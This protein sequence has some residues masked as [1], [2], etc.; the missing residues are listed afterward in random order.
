[1]TA[2]K[3][4][5][6]SLPG[7]VVAAIVATAA[8]AS[9]QDVSLNYERLSSMEEPLATEIGALTLVLNGVLDGALFRDVED[10]G[11]SGAGLTSNV[12]I[13]A[14]AQL[15][16]RWRVGAIWFGQYAASDLFGD[17]TGED[18]TDNVALSVGGV[19]GT[20]LAGNVSGAVSEE[21]RRLRGAGNA[22]LAFDGFLGGIGD[23]GAAYIGRFGPWTVAAAADR[24]G[25][26]DLGAMSQRP[27]GTSDYRVTLRA[28]S[29]EYA[30]VGGRKFETGGAGVVGELIHGSSAFD[31]G[32]GFERFMS[33]GADAGR[34]HVSA[35]ARRKT[36]AVTVSLEG[37]YGRVEDSEEVS[38][39]LGASYDIARGLS[40]NLGLNHARAEGTAD[41]VRVEDMEE[42]TAV[43]SI[44]YSF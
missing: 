40:A 22:A 25:D 13:A 41:G 10:G 30:V 18:Y 12:Q 15:P 1:M 19:W 4:L 29:G 23:A 31:A 9:G 33:S 2:L 32:L 11:A 3:A 7:S 38:A 43:L 8:P 36:G 27:H 20:A 14:L 6:S 37:H 17:D 16:N 42:T 39:A 44:R 24:D 26:F 21:T 5:R 34:W 28:Y 35:G